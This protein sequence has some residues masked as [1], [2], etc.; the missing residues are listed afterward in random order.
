MDLTILG[1]GHGAFAAAAALAESGHTVRWWRRDTA[2]L[3]ALGARG[4]LGIRDHRGLRQV[5]VGRAARAG[6]IRPVADLAEAVRGARLVVVPLP[7]TAHADLAPHLAPLLGDG[8]VVL[9]PPGTFGTVLFARAVADAGS[10][11]EVAFAETGTLPYLAR[12]HG[13]HEVAVSA[14]ATRL[15][16][17]VLPARSADAAFRVLRAAYPAVEPVEDCLSGALMN[18]GPVIHPPLIL[19]NAGP[20]EHGGSWDIHHEGT[21]PSV[22]RVTDALDAE[23][24]AVREA[25]AYRAPHFPLADHYATT[26]EEWMYGRAAHERLTGSGDWRE[27]IDLLHHRYL[28]EDTRLGLSFLVSV[29]RWAGCRT[30]VAQGLLSI[31]SAVTGTDLYARGRTLE[32]LDLAGLTRPAL[33]K[34][35][36]EG[37]SL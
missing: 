23:R 26:G 4:A 3:A 28:Q 9:L 12:T 6:A 29:G 37:F 18:A 7:A 25:L 34:L 21:Q 31:A 24:I 33:K 17:G 20:L 15:P 19:M 10:G 16:T 35:L 32:S 1:G 36:Y 11:A 22:R 13:P 5:P 14:Y 2:A 30:P 27:P 8:Q